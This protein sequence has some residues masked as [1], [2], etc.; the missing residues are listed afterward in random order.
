MVIFVTGTDTGVGKTTFSTALVRFWRSKGYNAIGLKPI[1]T[2]QREDALRLWEASAKTIALDAI[3]PFHFSQPLAPAIA[4]WL[5]G[6]EIKLE[7]IK[8][9]ISSAI[10]SYSHV[11]IE[12][13]G[14]WLTPLSRKWLLKDLVQVLHCPV[15]LIAHTRLGFL[16]H[17]FLSIES[18]LK[19]GVTLKGIILNRYPGLEID[20]MAVELLK[21]RYDLPI[22]FMDNL[23]KTPFNYP[24]WLDE[25]S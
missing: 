7:E 10:D 13:I 15:L 16:N 3:N 24:Q 22:A 17:S 14:G 8:K 11:V 5:E 19:A 6:K 25:T 21:E 23:D 20:P 1:S 9:A 2:G 4:S 12:G 18:I